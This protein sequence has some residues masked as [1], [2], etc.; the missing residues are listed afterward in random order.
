MEN[1][2][3]IEDVLE[4]LAWRFRDAAGETNTGDSVPRLCVEELETSDDELF[5]WRLKGGRTGGSSTIDGPVLVV[6]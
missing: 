3:T 2:H 1:S 4:A 6:D 5:L